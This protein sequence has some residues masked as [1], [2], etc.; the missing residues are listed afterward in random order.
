M[1]P[2]EILD[3]LHDQIITEWEQGRQHDDNYSK[4]VGKN[5]DT[6]LASLKKV[7]E[8]MKVDEE[9]GHIANRER[10]EAW[11]NAIDEIASIFDSEVGR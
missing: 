3:I 1:T 7:V 11:N 6:A 2:R 5:I 8:E 10:N 9:F 4:V